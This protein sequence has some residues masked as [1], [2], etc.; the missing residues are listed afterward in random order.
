ML[1]FVP[2]R[3]QTAYPKSKVLVPFLLGNEDKAWLGV[4]CVTARTN[5]KIDSIV[6]YRLVSYSHAMP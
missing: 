5:T 2:Y 4:L 1:L 6:V 3:N